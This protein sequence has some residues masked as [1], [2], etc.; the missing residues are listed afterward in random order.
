MQVLGLGTDI[1][2]IPRIADMLEKHGEHFL[3]R[4][5][6]PTEVEYCIGRKAQAQHLAGRWAAKEAVMKALGT[7]FSERVVFRDIEIQT[8]ISG[9]PIIVLHEGAKAAAE[10]LGI[11]RI[12][13]SISH[14][15]EYATATAIAL[16]D[17]PHDTPHTETST[18]ANFS[19]N[20]A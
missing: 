14:G 6:T 19:K 7:G 5:F 15:H 11:T 1:T 4:V 17:E 20:S 10:C 13:I 8:L 9:A 3:E 12:L 16:R 2:E 18:Q